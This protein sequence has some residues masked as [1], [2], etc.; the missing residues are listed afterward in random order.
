LE[1]R[2]GWRTLRLGRFEAVPALEL[3][4]AALGGA[5]GAA[6]ALVLGEARAE[7]EGAGVVRLEAHGAA[8]RVWLDQRGLRWEELAG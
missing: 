6:Y 4:A 7:A 1:P 2:R 3:E 8:A 5:W